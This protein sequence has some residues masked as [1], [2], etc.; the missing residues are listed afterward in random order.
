VR[1][2]GRLDFYHSPTEDGRAQV[3]FR[4][5]APPPEAPDAEYPFW[6]CTGRVLEHW[7]TGSLTMRIPQLAAAMPGA[8]V[9]LHPDDARALGVENGERVVLETRRGRLEL[10]AWLDGRGAPVPGSVFVPF[11]DERLPINELTLD[12]HDPF[13]KQPD[14]KK[15]AVR[16]RK[17]GAPRTS[18]AK[19][20]PA[21]VPTAPVRPGK[22]E[23]SGT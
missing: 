11:F 8:Y 23:R 6:L 18:D 10:P 7:H 20:G 4:P 21:T 9:E 15:C 22:P 17:A 5:Y 14:Y 12:A 13:S 16:I 3:W 1:G 2:E 19:P